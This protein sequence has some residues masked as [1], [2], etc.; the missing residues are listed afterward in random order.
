MRLFLIAYANDHGNLHLTHMPSLSVLVHA[1]SDAQH[2]GRLL[3][4]LRPADEVLVVDHAG[5]EAIRKVTHQY[6]A[7]LLPAVPG[8]DHGAYA[9]N[10]RHDWVL[11]LLASESL[12]ESL[13]ASLFEW[14]R[15]DQEAAES[16]AIPLREQHQS[17][18]RTLDAETRLVNR[19][20]V[21]WQGKLPP[22]LQGA[23]PLSGHLL[24]FAD[25]DRVAE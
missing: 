25:P 19:C 5:A 3:E 2:L 24:R 6:G 1:E 14:K 18:W 10:C 11:C 12:S 7:K 8:V 23:I 9:V 17:K 22:T 13:E 21:N 16:F 20:T 4:T 15:E